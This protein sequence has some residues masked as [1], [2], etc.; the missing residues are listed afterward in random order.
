MLIIT[1]NYSISTYSN[2][3]KSI[4]TYM[5]VENTKSNRLLMKYYQ[6]NFVADKDDSAETGVNL[7]FYLWIVA[8]IISSCYAY[9]WDIK[10]DWGLFDAKAGDNKFLREEIVYS[11]TVSIKIYC[12]TFFMVY[13]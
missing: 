7:F 12:L 6:K 2:A 3:K 11:S 10:L 13:I 8:S 4:E 1:Q 5:S 9:T